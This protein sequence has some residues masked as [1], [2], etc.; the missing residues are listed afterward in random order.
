MRV[1][2][3]YPLFR[4]A[5]HFPASDPI[6]EQTPV[7]CTCGNGCLIDWIEHCL[8]PGDLRR[9]FKSFEDFPELVFGYHRVS[10][11]RLRGG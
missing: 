4:E 10:V 2:W 7:A 11:T 6:K 1:K 5:D 9:W 3:I 8:K